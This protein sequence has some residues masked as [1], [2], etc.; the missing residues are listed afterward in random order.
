MTFVCRNQTKVYFMN[1]REYIIEVVKNSP[2]CY[3]RIISKNKECMQYIDNIKFYKEGLKFKTKLYCIIHDCCDE[4][5][6]C[7][8]EKCNKNIETD[9][10]TI[11]DGFRKY[12]CRT[13][14]NS[15]EIHK[16][17]VENTCEE[18]YGVKNVFQNQEIKER[19][20]KKKLE[21]YGNEKYTNRE[22]AKVT[23][24]KHILEN[25]NYYNDIHQKIRETN[26][27]NGHEPEWRNVQKNKETREKHMKE[28]PN[29]IHDIIQKTMDTKVRNGHSPTWN[30]PNKTKSTK[31]ERYG[32]E[33][34]NNI[35]K[36]KK[37]KKE[38]YGDE[39]YNNHEQYEQTC[40]NKYGVKSS[41][42]VES[43]VRKSRLS[44]VYDNQNFKSIPELAFYIWLKDNNIKFKYQP[45]IYFEYEFD[46]IKHKYHPDFQLL[47]DNK[48]IEIKG[49]HFFKA[50]GTM[51]CPFRDPSWDDIKY[52]KVCCK[53]EA[54]HQ[55]M[56]SNNVKILRTS[57]YK[58]YISYVNYKYG[59]DYI[60]SFK[61]GNS[62]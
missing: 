51:F 6:K 23:I 32:D 35:Q 50:D 57:E 25:Q 38:R 48:I 19:S 7:N 56:I 13:C 49:D 24:Q 62:K 33:N 59:N 21:K 45:N 40:I 17:Q 58:K 28:N 52:D 29:F 54:K 14:S 3:W 26:I 30:N 4:Y 31:K 11:H 44:Y 36:N 60:R 10:L 15:S 22:Q 42:M 41:M 27:K 37:T 34:Y 53:F 47:E 2:D 46:G 18:K 55:C 8:N 61:R 20:K 12:C 9:V 1:Y 43:I 16:I 39:N 5:P